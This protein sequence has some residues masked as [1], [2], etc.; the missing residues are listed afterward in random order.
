MS[1]APK[2]I[3]FLHGFLGTADD[4]RA[5]ADV[6][7]FADWATHPTDLLIPWGEEDSA[8]SWYVAVDMMAAQ[9]HENTI[10]VGYSMGAR[11]ALGCALDT[12]TPL[13]GLVLISG[14]PGL[15]EDERASRK[16]HDDVI[17]QRLLGLDGPA[18]K[19][20]FLNQW[21]RQPVFADLTD[22]QIAELIRYRQGFDSDRQSRLMSAYT[23]SKQPNYWNRLAELQVPTL[24]ITGQR[25]TKYTEIATRFAERCPTA[26]LSIVADAGHNVVREN[27]EAIVECLAK[28]A[29]EID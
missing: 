23:V 17:S 29:A 18:D 12:D 3:T 19:S 5:I 21:Y 7:E 16:A 27:S 9:L 6:P 4:W 2:S 15:A 8:G 10:L 25:D 13:R 28:F 26:K 1:D 24:V 11:V 14:S 22:E 20:D